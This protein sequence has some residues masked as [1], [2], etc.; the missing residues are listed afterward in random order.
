MLSRGKRDI[1]WTRDDP[2]TR[3]ENE[4]KT[5]PTELSDRQNRRQIQGSIAIGNEGRIDELLASDTSFLV[6][7]PSK[8]TTWFGEAIS[9][10]CSISILEKLFAAGCDPNSRSKSPDQTCPLEVA[11][12]KDRIDVMEWLI[13]HGADPNLGR[14]I[15][16]AIHFDKPPDI[17][18]RILAILL[19]AGA[20]V[21]KTFP[22]YGDENDRFTVLDWAILYD[23]SPEVIAYL[24]RKGAK[25]EYSSQRIA[26]MKLELKLR[27]I[28]P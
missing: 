27:R 24:E 22:L 9:D 10:N 23:V 26:E 25:R 28:V 20:N 11:V 7:P 12:R 17:Q 4:L 1:A 15:V 5:P 18:L 16:G 6:K 21:N 2:N 14:P 19:D 13:D 8:F 3:Y